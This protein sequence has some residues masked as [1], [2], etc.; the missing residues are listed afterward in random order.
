MPEPND[1][2]PVWRANLKS[3]HTGA[4]L[5][6]SSN[7]ELLLGEALNALSTVS[8]WRSVLDALPAPIYTTDADGAVTYWN[9]ACVALAGRVPEL[10]RDRWC[11]T[12]QIYTTTGE[13]M[14]H[15]ECP[16]AEAIRTREQVRDKVAIALRPDGSRVAFR[17]YPTPLF[18]CD[19]GF[20]GAINMLIDISDEQAEALTVEAERCRLLADATFNREVSQMLGNMADDYDRTA[21]DLSKKRS[22]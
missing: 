8:D 12:W 20:T 18:D 14:P 10:G 3:I 13:R 16:M 4:S 17:P 1:A 19:G 9:H 6:A 2:S 5:S 11:V 21:C 7:P 15:E 22:A